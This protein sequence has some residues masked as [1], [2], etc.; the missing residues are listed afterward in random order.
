[1]RSVFSPFSWDHLPLTLVSARSLSPLLRTGG[2]TFVLLSL[3]RRC[4]GSAQTHILF[5]T[6]GAL[7]QGECQQTFARNEKWTKKKVKKKK[8][9][10]YTCTNIYQN[11]N[12][13]SLALPTYFF[14]SWYSWVWVVWLRFQRSCT[15]FEQIGRFIVGCDVDISTFV[16]GFSLYFILYFIFSC[17][18]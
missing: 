8:K 13:K 5:Y 14:V 3:F 7:W 4:S 2:A 15:T 16:G 17:L 10:T 9:T 6:F 11:N 1:M 18:R 12:G